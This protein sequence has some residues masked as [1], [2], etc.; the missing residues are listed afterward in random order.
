V[1]TI[2][3]IEK[4]ATDKKTETAFI[5][6]FSALIVVIF[7]FVISMNGV[8]LGND[9]AVHLEKAKIFL[10][11][12]QISL[13]NL[14]WTPPLYAILLAMLISFSGAT[15]VGQMIFLVKV[16]AVVADWL[17]FMAVYLIGSKFFNRK[18]GVAAAIFLLM[19]FPTFEANQFGGYTTV[20]AL[21][22][23]FLVMLYVPLAIERFG[24]LVVAF[25]AAFGLVLSHQLAAFL[26]VFILPPVLLFMLIKSRGAYLKVVLALA[27]GGGIAF[28]L[29]YFQAM[30]GYLDIVIEYVFFAIKAYAYQIPAVSFGAFMT[31][32]GFI[33]VL[34]V[35]GIAIS[36]FALK[37]Q[38]KLVFFLI[39][40]LS[41]FVPLF[42]AESYLVGFYMPFGWF[43]YYLTPTMAILAA[44]S[45]VFFGSKFLKFYS[46][47][48][49]ASK[50]TLLK[51]ATVSIIVLLSVMVVF[52]S[53]TVYGRITEASVYYATTDMK[54]YDAGVWL[55]ANYP[56]YTVVI[57]T[58]VPGYWF[59]EFSGKETIAQ[60]DPAVQRTEIA[61]SVL[62]LSYELE[63]PQTLL[64]AYQAKGDTSDE[65]YVS[66]D[67]VW[68]RI[69]FSSATGD[70]LMY[71]ANGV[72]HK[73][74]L[75]DLSKQIV[76]E[77]QAAPKK[78]TFIYSNND[79]QLTKTIAV[80]N[81]TYPINVSYTL[82][83]LKSE[84]NNATLYLTTFFD[85]RFSLDK[86]QIP[87]LMDWINP[88]DAPAQIKTTHETGNNATDWAVANFSSSNL[89][90]SYIGLYD[91]K[92]DVAFGFK[93]NDLPDWGNI[94]ALANRQID[95]VR[96]QYQFNTVSANQTVSRSYQ[97]L[98][99]SKNSYS[100]L[101]P[102]G[103]MG[104]F[105]QNVPAFT[106]S[107][108]DFSDIIRDNGIGFI[109]YDRNKLDPQMVH[110]K[111]LQLI[112]SNDRYVIFKITTQP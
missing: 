23:M 83:P 92:N 107:A 61:E 32:F 27:L 8:V 106:V 93:F 29:Y 12:G 25:F 95:A 105:S 55:K 36:F 69:S 17:L 57:D 72:E 63:H 111:L 6:I 90:D 14:S 101:E 24:Y 65:L 58:Q 11:T 37:K 54:A 74:T 45:L 64:E 103:L 44:V 88:W 73:L 62:S 94:G 22:F 5:A 15:D 56:N 18:V 66:L 79:V 28:F 99:L 60:T 21:A 43:I 87:Q 52:R 46:K 51:I 34:A 76:F 86:A 89:Q 67:Q 98:T 108:R 50:K 77:D 1:N 7:Y 48:K 3:L 53:D 33:F 42:F 10:N 41:F 78:I 30:I 112:Y 68:N 110:S 35:A 91:D 102:S 75:S 39:L 82:T 71:M 40:V 38:K 80:E 20:L 100:P 16:I 31:N 9:P 4:L 104:M 19:C 109:V 2:A 49:N 70:F 81:T 96:F 85:L 47:N 13:A 59:K 97:M 26:A 84:I